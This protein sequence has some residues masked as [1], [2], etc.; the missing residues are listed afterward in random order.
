MPYGFHTLVCYLGITL[1]LLIHRGT[2]GYIF[3]ALALAVPWEIL[4]AVTGDVDEYLGA[5]ERIRP[6]QARG[7][8]GQVGANR[9][10]LNGRRKRRGRN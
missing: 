7:G 6:R 3:V 10:S 4:A 8:V 9:L 1:T 5:Q 2:E